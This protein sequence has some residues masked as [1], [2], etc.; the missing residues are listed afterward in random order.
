MFKTKAKQTTR[1]MCGF[2]S[3]TRSLRLEDKPLPVDTSESE[4]SESSF[5]ERSLNPHLGSM[6]RYS[7]GETVVSLSS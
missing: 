7:Q 5:N 2:S 3:T 6:I 4:G 1:A